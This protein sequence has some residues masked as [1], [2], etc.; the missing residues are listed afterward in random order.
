MERE[1]AAFSGWWAFW[2][3]LGILSGRW[4]RGTCWLAL[5]AGWGN[6]AWK[7]NAITQDWGIIIAWEG[8]GL[9]PLRGW[10][11]G[12]ESRPFW[13]E[14]G[15]RSHFNCGRNG[16]AGDKPWPLDRWPLDNLPSVTGGLREGS[17]RL[18]MSGN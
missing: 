2:I 17:W 8:G 18:F 1:P 10:S 13:L 9:V 4:E 3:G 14:E 5:M 12:C 7:D 11:R 6:R 16:D 15:M